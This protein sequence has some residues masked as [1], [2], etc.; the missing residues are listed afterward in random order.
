MQNFLNSSKYFSLD[1]SSPVLKQWNLT[2]RCRK[3]TKL[4]C[5]DLMILMKLYRKY[6]RA[7]D[8]LE[9]SVARPSALGR[10]NMDYRDINASDNTVLNATRKS[11]I[12]DF[13]WNKLCQ[14]C[15]Y[16]HMLHLL[17]LIHQSLVSAKRDVTPVRQHWS[18]ISLSLTHWHEW[19]MFCNH[20]ALFPIM[21]ITQVHLNAF[22][23]FQTIF[24]TYS[25]SNGIV[26]QVQPLQNGWKALTHPMQQ[27]EYS[28]QN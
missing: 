22:W 12:S 11:S 19:N 2:W 24:T 13:L 3:R 27:T 28:V 14:V 17:S 21:K 10:H 4:F 8:A 18:Y 9:T 5:M 15:K 26:R 6:Y 20:N 23:S 25:P 1:T 7:A 16:N